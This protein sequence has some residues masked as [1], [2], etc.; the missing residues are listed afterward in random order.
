MPPA[1]APVGGGNGDVRPTAAG[2]CNCRIEGTVVVARSRGIGEHV[3]IVLQVRESPRTA[4]TL[5][6]RPG[7]LRSFVLRGVPCGALHLEARAL[8]GARGHL[9][10]RG[11]DGLDC[12]A[13]STLR[14]RLTLARRPSSLRD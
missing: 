1:R 9:E 6:M 7:V 12:G 13:G 11:G 10:L 2:D 14:L 4:A 8:S 5:E 3:R